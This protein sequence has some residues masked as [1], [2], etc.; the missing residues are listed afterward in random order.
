MIPGA[1]RGRRHAIRFIRRWNN[2]FNGDVITCP[3]RM[4]PQG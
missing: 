4:L 1:T 2:Y 3:A